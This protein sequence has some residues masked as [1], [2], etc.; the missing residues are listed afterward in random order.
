MSYSYVGHKE[1]HWILEYCFTVLKCA[2]GFG[3]QDDDILYTARR[4]LIGGRWAAQVW[5]LETDGWTRRRVHT[6]H[7][8]LPVV[9][10]PV[11]STKQ[12]VKNMDS[13]RLP[14]VQ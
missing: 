13:D 12:H 5:S 7:C 14:L 3:I 1:T 11:H 9:H 6:A 2:L 4:Q 8:T 10:C